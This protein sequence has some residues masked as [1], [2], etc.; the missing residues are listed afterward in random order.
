[1]KPTNKYSKLACV[2]DDDQVFLSLAKKIITVKKFCDDV[3]IF[4]SGEEAL[5]FFKNKKCIPDV[6]LLD[7]NMPVM[8]GWDFLNEFNYLK[9]ESSKKVN[10]YIVSS[11]EDPFDYDKAK[12]TDAVHDYISK[13]ITI[14]VFEQIFSVA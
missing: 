5:Q 1:M 3:L 4:K 6:I 13:P 9:K 2:I 11:S 8:D 14:P 12:A 10:L 7:L